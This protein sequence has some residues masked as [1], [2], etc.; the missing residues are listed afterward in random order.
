MA[1]NVMTGP[2][3]VEAKCT[4]CGMTRT[5]YTWDGEPA[6]GAKNVN[7]AQSTGLIEADCW[8]CGVKR[9]FQRV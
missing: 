8:K 3:P 5:F 1:V 4:V 7:V 6:P 9:A 2:P